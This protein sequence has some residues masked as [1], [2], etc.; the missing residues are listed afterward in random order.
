MPRR[1]FNLISQNK[2]L[3]K[4]FEDLVVISSELEIKVYKIC[5]IWVKLSPKDNEIFSYKGVPIALN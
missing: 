2:F 5:V 1:N 4:G 3:T